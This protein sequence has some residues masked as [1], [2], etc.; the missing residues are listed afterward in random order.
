[1]KQDILGQQ[2]STMKSALFE[3]KILNGYF[4]TLEVLEDKDNPCFIDEVFSLYFSEAEKTF[5]EIETVMEK[6]SIDVTTLYNLLH[7]LKGSSLSIGAERVAA[8][9]LQTMQF[10]REKNLESTKLGVGKLISEQKIL[11]TKLNSY[12]LLRREAKNHGIILP[13][14]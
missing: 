9:I 10:L 13:E 1:M 6:G 12:L 11:K 7:R 4:M 8:T 2:V 14:S 3:E 5:A